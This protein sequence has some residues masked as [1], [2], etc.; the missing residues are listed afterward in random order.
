MSKRAIFASIITF[1]G[2]ILAA[3]FLVVGPSTHGMN[4]RLNPEIYAQVEKQEEITIRNVTHESVLY[5]I[6]PSSSVSDPVKMTIQMGDIDRFPGNQ[7]MDISFQRGTK[8]ISY[9]LDTGMPYSFRYDENDELE[10]Y[11]GSHGSA[12]APDLA[13]FVPTPVVV[14]EKMLEMAEVNENDILYDLGCGDGRI[15]I[16]AAKKYGARGVGIDIDPQRIEEANAAAKDAGVEDLVEFR[17][18]DVFKADFSEATVIVLYLLSESNELLRPFFDRFLQPGT[19]V[20]SHNYPI[21]GW[22]EKEM[23]YA[24]VKVEDDEEQ[25]DVYL[26]RR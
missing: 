10:L 26:Y 22:K 13:P 14:V 2:L 20:V 15:V 16:L 3:W 6:K 19:R 23:E 7:S 12:D 9:R 17:R 18:Q 4:P 5:R 25:H 1:I 24:S 21:P 11:E 8:T